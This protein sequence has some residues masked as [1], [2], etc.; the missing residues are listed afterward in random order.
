VA[1]LIITMLEVLLRI[2]GLSLLGT[3][4]AGLL[5]SPGVP[6]APVIEFDRSRVESI[7]VS[8]GGRGYVD[9]LRRPDGSWQNI[10]PG[11]VR[12][13]PAELAPGLL[14]LLGGAQSAHRLHPDRIASHATVFSITVREDAAEPRSILIGGEV[15][16]GVHWVRLD[17]GEDGESRFQVIPTA[18]VEAIRGLVTPALHDPSV[19][20]R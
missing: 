3:V 14:D 6:P 9:L 17:V 20:D 10:V 12:E 13:I 11:A 19:G 4:A 7:A 16:P 8:T 15:Y 1:A 5:E 18:A 2:G